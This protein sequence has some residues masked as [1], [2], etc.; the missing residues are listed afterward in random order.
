MRVQ[1]IDLRPD[2]AIVLS[3]EKVAELLRVQRVDPEKER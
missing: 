1:E 3:L 2:V